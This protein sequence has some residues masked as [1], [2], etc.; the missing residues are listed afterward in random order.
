[1]GMIS[2]IKTELRENFMSE[3]VR[4]EI[5]L[6]AK[7]ISY[8]Y[9]DG[10]RALDDVSVTIRKGRKIALMG[11]NGSGKST[12]FLCLNGIYRPQTGE[13]Y[14]DGKP[15]DYS[16]KGLLKLRSQVGIVFQDPDNQL[17]IGNVRQEIS[18]GILNM[19]VSMSETENRVDRVIREL[20][21]DEFAEKPTHALSG[22]QKKQV[23]IADILVMG[24]E[25]IILDEPA[26]SLDPLHIQIIREMIDKLTER[27]IT[28]LI[29]THDADFAYE[30][31]DEVVLF[32]EGKVMLQ[33]TPMEVFT[34]KAMLARTHLKQPVVMELFC[35]LQKKALLPAACQVPKTLKE[36][37]SCIEMMRPQSIYGGRMNTEQEKKAVLVVSF[38]TSHPD[39]REKTIDKIENLIA[40]HLTDCR[41]YRAW[42]SGMIIEKLRK[43]DG[44]EVDTVE[45]SM[46]RMISD[47]VTQV[48]VQPTHIVNGVENDRM[49]RDVLLYT[50][51]FERIRF[52]TPLLTEDMDS[53]Q[54]IA[55]VM[56][57]FPQ[58]DSE[59]ALIF[60]GHGT[61]HYANAIY[62]ALDYKFKDMGYSNVFVGTVEAYPS[63]ETLKKMVN[64]GGYRRVILTPFMIVAGEHAKHDM[65]SDEEDSWKCQFEREGLEV[66]CVVKGLGEYEAVRQ[67]FLEHARMA[68]EEE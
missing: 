15:Y 18:F 57:E 1:M 29:A 9:E 14:K 5:I 64:E 53:E 23:A 60:M 54:V 8:T 27:G 62:A 35:R 52:G 55:G 11:A 42:T 40:D 30:W 66:S 38:G 65:A 36:L 63:M 22:G 58:L 4:N 46:K 39:T 25:I 59:T 68:S 12:F 49:K 37:E 44:Y 28:V 20:R 7:Q 17:V 6:E 56:R 33:G 24:P 45:E 43:R 21:I 2:K 67:L 31:A 50:D 10:T 51:Q 47:G 61:T 16:R 19:G 3:D 34:Q 48:I 41:M 26:A 32:R 13:L